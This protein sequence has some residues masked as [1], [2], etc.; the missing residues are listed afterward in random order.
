MNSIKNVRMISYLIGIVVTF[1]ISGCETTTKPTE[2][3]LFDPL[4]QVV[5]FP[6]AG[7][8]SEAEIGETIISKA[9]LRTY[10]AIIT[11]NNYEDSTQSGKIKIPA[12]KLIL[13]YENT[14][15]NFFVAENGSFEGDGYFSSGLVGTVGIFVPNNKKNPAVLFSYPKV[16]GVKYSQF[17][18]VPVEYDTSTAEKYDSDS[19][20]IELIYGGLTQKTISLSYREFKDGTARSAFTQ[21]LKYDL[22]D[23]DVIGFRGARFQVLKATNTNIRYKMLKPIN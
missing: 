14:D 22:N 6:S 12:G 19:F 11:Q 18:K 3:K 16:L 13:N 10:P 9:L 23:S 20:K 15:G 7:Q 4:K 17:G 21:E 8:V 5:H 1:M 2:A